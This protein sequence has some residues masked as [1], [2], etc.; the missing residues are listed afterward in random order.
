MSES[1]RALIVAN[2]ELHRHASATFSTPTQA[3]EDLA[4][5]LEDPRIGCFNVTRIL[6]GTS[7]A[8]ARAIEQFFVISAPGPEDLL[9]VYF[10]GY[11]VTV[12][13]QL[14][15]ATAGTPVGN[16]GVV[17]SNGL[18]A[19]FIDAAMRL[20]RCRRQV[21]LLDGVN[22]AEISGRGGAGTRHPAS[23]RKSFLPF[24][25]GGRIVLAGTAEA[26]VSGPD[27]DAIAGESS[28]FT[29]L[30]RRGLESG[31]A[32][33]NGDGAVEVDE[34]CQYVLNRLRRAAP[35]R[36]VARSGHVNGPIYIARKAAHAREIPHDLRNAFDAP[37]VQMRLAAVMA[38]DELGRG[39]DTGLALAAREALAGKLHTDEDAR[40]REAAARGLS[41]PTFSGGTFADDPQAATRRERSRSHSSAQRESLN[42]TESQ[43]GNDE[44]HERDGE[45]GKH[46]RGRRRSTT[47]AAFGAAAAVVLIAATWLLLR[48]GSDTATEGNPSSEA[49]AATD[50][51]AGDATAQ[52]SGPFDLL[53]AS[54]PQT[55][56]NHADGL[57]YVFVPAGSFA[58][59]CSPGDTECDVDEA[60]KPVTVQIP[61]GFWLGQTEVTQAAWKRINHG[62]NPSHFKGDQLP[63]ENI[64]GL[65]ADNYCDASVEGRLPTE[66]EWEYAAR[67]GTAGARYAGVD[68]VAWYDGN[69][70]N[71]THA[72]GQKQPNAFGLYDML[73]NV[74]EWT[75]DKRGP[76]ARAVRGGSWSIGGSF[77]RASAR[78]KFEN[79]TRL[80]T[81][82]FRCVAITFH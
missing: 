6:N 7:S 27:S 58:M 24:V 31:K 11:W 51:G 29:R 12:D 2:S 14:Y 30:L 40:V 37:E 38:L 75:S 15:L 59:G 56:L 13:G 66:K 44:L 77:A 22:G 52:S 9:L 35:H 34:L 3:A 46:R 36:T 23:P 63:V 21:L 4:R 61:A 79:T 57:T 10:S 25:D 1:R 41:S 49:V 78:L 8:I 68:A 74:M 54:P 42:S 55:R 20:C 19:E 48:A 76:D 69:S 50:S 70:G 71:T 53:A 39:K 60:R 65:D 33:R 32:D 26:G 28:L 16:D 17:P 62:H 43:T 64:T 72:V 82:G 80:S 18:N 67:A 81:L 47:N 45:D 5:V 73:G